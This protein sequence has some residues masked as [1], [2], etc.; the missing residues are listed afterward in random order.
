MQ[1]ALSKP[2]S[3]FAAI[4]LLLLALVLVHAFIVQ[5]LATSWHDAVDS[6]EDARALA[7]RYARTAAARS[8]Y[9][10]QAAALRAEKPNSQW[11]L[12]GE[13]DALAA[14][15]M[16]D[17]INSLTQ[18]AGAEIRSIQT[19]PAVN[20][21]GLRRIGATVELAAKTA[22]LLRVAYGI[23][24]GTPYLFINTAEA[25]A[26]PSQGSIEDPMLIVRLEISGYR[27]PAQQ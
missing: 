8:Q 14:A 1:L 21:D 17:R 12:M 15:A 26:D 4:G 27:N 2:V 13:T 22:A 11:F 24:S 6:I 18:A 20:E 16:Q 25:V 7:A 5:P 19:V 9:E 23:E 3:R 10:E